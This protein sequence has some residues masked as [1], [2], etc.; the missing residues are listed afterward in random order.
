VSDDDIDPEYIHVT[1]ECSQGVHAV[2]TKDGRVLGATHAQ[3][4]REGQALLPGQVLYHIEPETGK[5]MLV[6]RAPGSGPAKVSS[7]SYRD[8][9][10]RIFGNKTVGQA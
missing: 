7:P 8:G 4:A 9:W 2:A 5:V 10:D 6:T 1:D 3:R